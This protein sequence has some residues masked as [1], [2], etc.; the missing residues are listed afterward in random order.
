MCSFSSLFCCLMKHFKHIKFLFYAYVS[1]CVKVLCEPLCVGV[2]VYMRIAAC[3]ACGLSTRRR[4]PGPFLQR[5][6]QLRFDCK[7]NSHT[8]TYAHVQPHSLFYVGSRF[9]ARHNLQHVDTLQD[10]AQ[11]EGMR[12]A[13]PKT[14]A[15]FKARRS[16]RG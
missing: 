2:C 9:M 1:V 6:C 8:H 10:D 16:R 4:L 12:I 7:S 11:C 3:Q 15:C 5:N 13:R 14:V